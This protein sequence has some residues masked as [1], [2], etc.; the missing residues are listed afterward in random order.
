MYRAPVK[1]LRFVL[2]ELLDG[3]QLRACPAFADYSSETADAVLGEAARFAETVLE[4]L[5]KSGDRE[6]ARWSATGV[7]MPEGF[8]AA[9]QQF[10]DSGWPALRGHAEF[11][12]QN[13]P[14]ALGTAVEE[15][16]ASSNLAFKLCPMLTLGA[17]EA[18]QHFAS[19]ELQQLYLPKMIRGEWT[20]TMNLTEPQAGSDLAQV[21]TRAAPAGPNYRI[22]GQKIFITYGEHDL[23]ENIVH[24]VLARID[25]APPGVRGISLFMVP[26]YWVNADGSLG[27]RND[28]N[29]AS[30]EHKLG[31]H[32]SPTCVMMYGENEG[33]LGVLVGEAN[34]GLEYMFVM[35]NAARL[36]VGLEGYAQ[37]ER[38]FQQAAE[39]ARTRVQ[40]K[41]PL[42]LSKVSGSASMGTSSSPAPIIG[43]PDVKRMLLTMKSTVEACRAL[44]LYAAYQL[45][46]GGGHPDP[47]VRQAAQ[48]RGDL[49]IPIVKGYCTE[50]GI[51]IASTGIQV[52]GGMGY[53]EETGAA[54]T[55]RDVRIT[56]IY[57]G[58]TG[59]Q[60]NDLIGRKIGRDRGAT[61][62]AFIEEMRGSL[63]AL[64][65]EHP[66][67]LRVRDASL[68][69]LD[70]L[71]SAAES[72]LANL[73]T[74][75]DRAMAVS[76]PFLKLCGITIGGW[77]MAR[78]AEIAARKLAQGASDREFLQAK[79]AS[80]HFYATQVLPQALSLEHIVLRGSEAVIAADAALI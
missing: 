71:R 54:Q 65:P 79:I 15:L 3:E 11:G 59:I 30:I 80:A 61:L 14:A 27:A 64:A 62:A 20:G 53:V 42:P 78:A 50:A 21:R 52:H 28:L 6:G 9:Y 18:I 2:D 74:A 41:P 35:M 70:R 72:L 22:Y 13:V 58:T 7:T 12:G 40:G 32:A 55:L 43:H 60:S 67:A 57:E 24:M 49:L 69:S 76:V 47:A 1:D 63:Q 51:E 19:H 34:R 38:A 10:C 29:C 48:A 8:K 39:W 36:S 45:D 46:L 75:P 16:W 17:I 37:G 56:S 68:E 25:G 23:A 26:K 73:A 66:D 33:A 44:A 5:C 31:I 4:P 77:L